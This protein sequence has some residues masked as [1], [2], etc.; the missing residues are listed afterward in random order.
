MEIKIK[1]DE[2][3]RIILPAEIREKYHLTPESE[4]ILIEKDEEIILKNQSPKYS[5]EDILNT[6][7]KFDPK[8]AL[9]IDIGNLDEKVKKKIC[10]ELSPISVF[11][12]I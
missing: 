4:I 8:Q 1:M 2:E 11:K 5:L 3:G 6:P 9:A 10:T 7:I 12:A